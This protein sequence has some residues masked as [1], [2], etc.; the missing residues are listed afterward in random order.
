[1]HHDHGLEQGAYNF[2]ALFRFRT[3]I[4]FRTIGSRAIVPTRIYIG[5]CQCYRNA[6]QREGKVGADVYKHTIGP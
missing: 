5:K 4:G 3:I 1:M 2:E 6:S